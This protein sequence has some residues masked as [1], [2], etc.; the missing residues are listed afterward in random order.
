[1]QLLNPNTGKRAS[2][3]IIYQGPSQIDGAPIV[4]V[5]LFG[6][7]NSKTGSMMQ[8]YI[9]RADMDPLSASKSGDDHAICGNCPHRGDAAPNNDKV[10]QATNRNCYV[11]LFHGPLAVY[12]AFKKGNYP[13]VTDP[14]VINEMG[15]GRSVR[16]GTYGDPLAAPV[17][18]WRQLV[19]YAAAR[20]GYTHQPVL[21][22]KLKCSDLLMMSA[23]TDRDV[24][25]FAGQK[26]RYFRVAPVGTK[27]LKNEIHC[28]AS[29]ERGA[30]LQCIDCKACSGSAGLK[31]Q[32]VMIW[33]H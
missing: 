26:M 5:A 16:L 23:D 21:A 6:S 29:K 7:T 8:T 14:A 27:A 17:G 3:A 28:P 2:G 22:A 25:H 20:T 9:I 11:T 10:K 33:N 1:M 19:R 30:K 13:I 24:Q 15:R 12:K 18:L 31:S 32:G 4:V